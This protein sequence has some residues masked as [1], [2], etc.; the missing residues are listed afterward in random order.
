MDAVKNVVDETT[1]NVVETTQGVTTAVVETTKKGFDVTVD[2][3]GKAGEASTKFG[4]DVF[5]QTS[6]AGAMMMG[7]INGVFDQLGVSAGFQAVMMGFNG[8]VD[9]T[10]SGLEKLF[11]EIDTSGDGF[12]SDQEMI[13]AIAKIYGDAVDA[14]L[15]AEMMTAADSNKD[16][17][18]S[19]D[20][21]KVIMRCVPLPSE[22]CGLTCARHNGG[23]C[24][25]PA[26]TRCRCSP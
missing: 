10:D 17:K 7:G 24:R 18:I 3:A 13:D 20:E 25:L 9:T 16:G 15:I 14:A 22:A 5:D 2:A 26:T 19:L 21:F 6:A 12:L 23:G 4:K 11:K 1:K 8:T